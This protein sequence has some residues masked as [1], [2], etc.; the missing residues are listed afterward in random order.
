[1]EELQQYCPM[2]HKQKLVQTPGESEPDTVEQYHYHNILFGGDQ[3]TVARIRGSQRI[4]QHSEFEKGKLEG[5]VP[6]VEDWHTKVILL[7]VH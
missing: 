1:M 6:C 2:V 3:L 7:E 4:R 5:L